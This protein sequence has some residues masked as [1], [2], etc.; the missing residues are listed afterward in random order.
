MRVNIK[1]THIS[2]VLHGII[3]IMMQMVSVEKLV[4]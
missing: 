4:V 3:N 1:E 2:K